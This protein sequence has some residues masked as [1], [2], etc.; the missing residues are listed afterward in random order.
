MA[1]VFKLGRDKKKRNAPWYFEYQDHDGK[2]RMRKGFTEKSL[3]EQFA[4]KMETEAR[5]RRMGFIDKQQANLAE[6][7]KSDVAARVKEY[8]RDLTRRKNTEKHVKLTIGRVRRVIVGCGFKT[9]GDITAVAVD[10]YVVKLCETEELGH[11][12]HNHYLQA[13][14]GFCN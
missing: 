9:L 10:D 3:T 13:M 7:Q 5:L 4:V 1:S 12:T 6:E 11:R 14:E 2:K 8:E